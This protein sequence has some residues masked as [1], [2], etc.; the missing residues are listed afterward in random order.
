M[1][2]MDRNAYRGFVGKTK[3]KA[4][5]TRPKRRWEDKNKM[6]IKP[7]VHEGVYWIHLAQDGDK[8]L[9]LV[10]MVKKKFMFGIS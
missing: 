8:W 9:G 5:F 7:P 4:P 2:G 3:D 1:T 6:D 10:N